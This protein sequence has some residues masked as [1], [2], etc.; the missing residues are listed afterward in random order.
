[1][2][3]DKKHRFARGIVSFAICLTL[4]LV[5]TFTCL[6]I[7]MPSRAAT[8][9]PTDANR[10][11]SIT[12]ANGSNPFSVRQYSDYN[13]GGNPSPLAG[14][15]RVSI[16]TVQ[17]LLNNQSAGEKT[18]VYFGFNNGSVGTAA[19]GSNGLTLSSGNF[20]LTGNVSVGSTQY[21]IRI[22]NAVVTCE[23]FVLTRN[24]SG[25]TNTVGFYLNNAGAVVNFNSGTLSTTGGNFQ[26]IRNESTGSINISGGTITSTNGNAI[27]N[28]STGKISISG[29]AQVSSSSNYSTIWLG[30]GIAGQ[31]ILNVSGGTISAVN[32]IAVDNNSTG[33]VNISGGTITSTNDRAINNQSTGKISISGTAQV[34]SSNYP[35]IWLNSGI[36]GQEILNISGGT[37]ESTGNDA[38]NDSISAGGGIVTIYNSATI[39]AKRNALYLDNMNLIIGNVAI[40]GCIKM[41]F[42]LS[43][44]L[45]SEYDSAIAQPFEFELTGPTPTESDKCIFIDNIGSNFTTITEAQYYFPIISHTLTY[46]FGM[47]NI[48][49]YLDDCTHTNMSAWS[50][51]TPATCTTVGTQTRTCLDCG[52]IETQTI[53]VL[54]HS[55]GPWVITTPPT[56]LDPGEETR[57]CTHDSNHTQ[58]QAIP[59]LGDHIWSL[60]TVTTAPTCTLPGEEE[61]TCSHCTEV[62]TRAVDP[63]GHDYGA[64]NVTTPATC[65]T[66]GVETRVCAH[67]SGHTETQTIPA[68]GHSWGPWVVTTPPTALDPGEETRTCTHDSNHTQTQA[69]PPL[70]GYTEFPITYHN[71]GGADNSENPTLFKPGD[72]VELKNPSHRNGYNFDGWY[73]AE[74]GGNKIT[75]ISDADDEI[76]LWARWTQISTDNWWKSFTKS[77]WFFVSIVALITLIGCICATVWGL[78]NNDFFA[79]KENK[80]KN[81]N[82]NKTE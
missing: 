62:E 55:W 33:S 66:A 46:E 39:V 17:T 4:I 13:F 29:T 12:T 67:D 38:I 78:T 69:I 57:T 37:I 14:Y 21:C 7:I 42:G 63:L 76:I 56:A 44:T 61:R 30:T 53:P 77:Q 68:L 26:P 24:N 82:N 8:I 65:T 31:E 71:L 54:G 36:A 10:Y 27:N 80:K 28:N 35:T 79:D 58:T 47:D 16:S 11:F 25:S 20:Y 15:D 40:E 23:D 32:T 6:G 43:R 18:V 72:L 51:V 52:Y 60:W 75:T 9:I 64:W 19:F 81:K 59:P 48:L 41:P 45:H 5:S 2:L 3:P 49:V 50:T 34:S 70:G 73:D 1:M 74:T 22:N